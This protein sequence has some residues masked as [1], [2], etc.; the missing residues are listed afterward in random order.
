L[1]IAISTDGDFVSAHFGRCPSFTIID[2]EG[3]K[4]SEKQLIN[5][6]GHRPNFL[7]EFLKGKGVKCII[8]GGMGNQAAELFKASGIETIIG[9]EGSVDSVI[10]RVLNGT[11]KGGENLCRPDKDKENRNSDGDQLFVL[12][13]QME[14]LYQKS[15]EVNEKINKLSRGDIQ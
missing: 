14:S 10:N 7:P 8:S 1:K 6:P 4:L 12:K 2:I 13:R 15:K 9:A 3:N 5:N 11:L